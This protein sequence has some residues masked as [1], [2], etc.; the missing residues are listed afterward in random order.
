MELFSKHKVISVM[1]AQ[2]GWRA[3]YWEEIDGKVSVTSSPLVCWAHVKEFDGDDEYD[4]VEAMDSSAGEGEAG[5]C[6]ECD[7]F[8]GLLYPGQSSQMYLKNAERAM[9]SRK[10]MESKVV[11]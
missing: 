9:E 1:P 6:R 4:H 7:N 2:E 10:S 5:F 3:A 11:T 8:L